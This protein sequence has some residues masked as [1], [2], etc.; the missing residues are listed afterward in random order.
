V[1]ILPALPINKAKD[2]CCGVQYPGVQNLRLIAEVGSK[3]YLLLNAKG[4]K[5]WRKG[6]Q[7]FIFSGFEWGVYHLCV[8]SY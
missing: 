5:G 6:T 4:R 1:G 8:P 2:K 7:R 3:L